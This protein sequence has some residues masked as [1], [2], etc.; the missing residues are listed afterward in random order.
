MR[1]SRT[2]MPGAHDHGYPAK[3]GSVDVLHAAF[4]PR[5]TDR[6]FDATDLDRKSG[7]ALESF[8]EVL[9]QIQFCEFSK[10]PS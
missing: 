9:W 2:Q 1:L 3:L 6:K 4:L 5:K 7:N 8:S 10:G